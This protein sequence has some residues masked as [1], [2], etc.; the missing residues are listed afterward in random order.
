MRVNW[1]E[2]KVVSILF[3]CSAAVF[4]CLCAFAC[5][6]A[7]PGAP[8]FVNSSAAKNPLG[9]LFAALVVA[10]IPSVVVLFC[11]MAIFCACAHHSIRAKVFWFVLF[12]G[13]GPIG[14]TVYYFA[15]YR[16][17]HEKDCDAVSRSRF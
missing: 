14:S 5:L 9:V 1:L 3:L 11:G 6:L 8:Q 15:V 17:Y 16:G 13:T 10:G 2:S 4:V 12:L 7:I